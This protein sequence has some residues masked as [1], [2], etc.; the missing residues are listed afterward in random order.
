MA[1]AVQKMEELELEN[2]KLICENALNLNSIFKREIDTIFLNFSDPWPK[3][4]HSKRR[5]TSD[6]FMNIYDDLFKGQK[7]IILKTDNY[8]LYEYSLSQFKKHNYNIITTKF[9]INSIPEGNIMTE[10]EEKFLN[11]NNVI[12]KIE[13]IRK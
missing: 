9:D 11:N 10:Y 1:R 3:D 5:L 7:N 12:Y 2:I 13:A 6:I 4:R 8:G